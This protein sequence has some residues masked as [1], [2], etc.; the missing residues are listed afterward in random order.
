MAAKE[1]TLVIMKDFY[2]IAYCG[3]ITEIKERYMQTDSDIATNFFN[4]LF[5][6]TIQIAVVLVVTYDL[7]TYHFTYAFMPMLLARYMGALRIHI[8][9]ERKV[10]HALELLKYCNNHPD[11]FTTV[12]PPYTLASMLL[13]VSVATELANLS[14]VCC[15]DDITECIIRSVALIVVSECSEFYVNSMERFKLIQ[16]VK[17][18]PKITNR[19]KDIKFDRRSMQNK[20]MRVS[21][22]C[23]R[24]IYSSVYYYFMP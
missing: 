12:W 16:V 20:I 1:Q 14:L 2:S 21:Y 15:I 11:K 3:Y 17:D 8:T 13:L 9:L 19:S 18:P 24:M 4:C 5:L 6:F 10:T 22:K 7:L 23:L